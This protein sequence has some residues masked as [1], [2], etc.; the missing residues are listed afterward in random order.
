MAD[1]YSGDSMV[2]PKLKLVQA[3]PL[4]EL[5]Q[6]LA[7]I[8]RER[9]ANRINKV[10]NDQAVFDWVRGNH[11]G[12]LDLTPV[13]AN[14]ANILLMGQYGGI[15]FMH[16]QPGLYEAHTQVLPEG[17]GKWTVGM[18]RAA[19]H[20]M[21]TRSDCFEV[22][23]RCPQ[24]NIAARALIKRVGGELEFT[25]Q[26]GW[27]KN[28]VVIPADIYSWTIQAWTRTAPGLEERGEWLQH[29]VA[30]EY[31]RLNKAAIQYVDDKVFN[32]YSGMAAEMFMNKQ[33]A[34]AVLLYNRWAK[35][36]GYDNIDLMCAENPT[37]VRTQDAILMVR[38]DGEF[39][40]ASINPSISNLH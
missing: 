18:T 34:K 27:V 3:E 22:L 30:R 20:W 40:V 13:I 11:P 7:K 31:K 10:V 4:S 26:R 25:N 16:L 33:A 6:M 9:H 5:H 38:E 14:P 24:G 1:S 28:D 39:Y 8:G 37:A 32:R 36:A 21:F 2:L 19:L 17:R 23:S 15:L 12:P 35:V 29:A